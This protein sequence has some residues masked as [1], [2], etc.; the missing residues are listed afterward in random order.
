M[1]PMTRHFLI[2]TGARRHDRAPPSG[3]MQ[4]AS[5]T[6]DK[7]RDA[8]IAHDTPRQ[9]G[10]TAGD[11]RFHRTRTA[12]A[13]R[14]SHGIRSRCSPPCSPLQALL[15]RYTGQ[16]DIAIG[17]RGRT[18]RSALLDAVANSSTRWSCARP[19]ARSIRR[20]DAS[21]S[22]DRGRSADPPADALRAPGGRPSAT[23]PK[24]N[25]HCRSL[26]WRSRAPLAG[27]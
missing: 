4:A 11:A 14:R 19:A 17:A 5:I 26:R 3:G 6:G 21:E 20:V 23:R 15:L 7:L 16:T 12:T 2:A 22:H 24:P 18:R 27:A 13:L 8:N 25:P 10:G 1:P 9:A